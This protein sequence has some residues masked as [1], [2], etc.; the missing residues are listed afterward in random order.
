MRVPLA[1][2][3]KCPTQGGVEGGGGI[4]TVFG[5]SRGRTGCRLL[6]TQSPREEEEDKMR[7]Q[8]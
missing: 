1:G 7:N 2:V 4:K 5:F 6:G 3:P 8:H